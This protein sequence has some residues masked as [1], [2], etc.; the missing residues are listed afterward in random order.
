[1]ANKK[2]TELD[3]GTL[4]NSSIFATSELVGEDYESKKVTA[5]DV[6][7]FVASSQQYA[8]LDTSAKTLIGAINEAAQGGGGGSSTL[9]GLSDVS[10]TTLQNGQLMMYNNSTQKWYNT[11]GKILPSSVTAF[12]AEDSV[13]EIE[14]SGGSYYISSDFTH[15]GWNEYNVSACYVYYTYDALNYKVVFLGLTSIVGNNEEFI[16]KGGYTF[17]GVTYHLTAKVTNA[18]IGNDMPVDLSVE[19]E[20]T[21]TLT[22]GST[23]IT[24]SDAAITPSSTIE[25]F[26]EVYGVSPTAVSVSNGS[27]TMTFEAQASN[28]GVKVRV[29]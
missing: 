10:F 20:L 1:M 4:A 19:F 11:T 25:I 5:Q 29:S 8:G 18:G 28:M 12:S 7:N 16:F 9:A 6:G 26:T 3:N 27:V 23:S 13:A 15:S 22:A 24:L 14:E 2:F 17:N 21:G